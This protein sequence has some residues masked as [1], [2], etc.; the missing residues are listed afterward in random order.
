L[1][2]IFRADQEGIGSIDDYQVFRAKEGDGATSL[3]KGEGISAIQRE[4]VAA[5]G[6]SFFIGRK[7]G[8]ESAP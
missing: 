7:M 5:E 2:P 3:G 6:V 1:N 8:G 4:D